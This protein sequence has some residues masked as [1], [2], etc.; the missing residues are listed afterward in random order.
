MA[1]LELILMILTAST[2]LLNTWLIYKQLRFSGAAPEDKKDQ[3]HSSFT[4]MMISDILLSL[5]GCIVQ[6]LGL[7]LYSFVLLVQ[8]SYNYVQTQ[9]VQLYP[10]PSFLMLQTNINSC[11]YNHDLHLSNHSRSRVWS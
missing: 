5:H 8:F 11:K 1:I 9:A 3:H 2:L 7:C 6:P 10:I 4:L